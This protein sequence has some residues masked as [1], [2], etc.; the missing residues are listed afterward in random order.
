MSHGYTYIATIVIIIII[1]IIIIVIVILNTLLWKLLVE[2]VKIFVK[3]LWILASLR[4]DVSVQLNFEN[5]SDDVLGHNK[6][7]AGRLVKIHK[8]FTSIINTIGYLVI[9]EIRKVTK[10]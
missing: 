5:V 7:P 8:V 3:N 1:I 2:D 10:S 9:Q 6:N 4:T